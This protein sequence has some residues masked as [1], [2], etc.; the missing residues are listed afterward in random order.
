MMPDRFG[1]MRA[2]APVLIAAAMVCAAGGGNARQGPA[3]PGGARLFARE[4]TEGEKNFFNLEAHYTKWS[5][6]LFGSRRYHEGRLWRF[7]VKLIGKEITTGHDFM[8]S[9]PEG[10][11]EKSVVCIFPSCQWLY[12]HGD[13]DEE[14][15]AALP[16]ADYASIKEWWRSGRTVAVTGKVRKFKLDW[17]R[18][19]DTLHLWLEKV[20]LVY[21]NGEKQPGR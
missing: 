7:L 20:T 11:Y 9:S 3:C 15:V 12:I 16:G 21:G 14:S 18:R 5:E 19:G 6:G 8:L 13:L 10:V 4:L 1:M 2:A 17:D